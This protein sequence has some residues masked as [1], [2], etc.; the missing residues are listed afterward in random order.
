MTRNEQQAVE[1]IKS[2]TGWDAKP[3]SPNGGIVVATRPNGARLVLWR[4]QAGVWKSAVDVLHAPSWQGV[5]PTPEAAIEAVLPRYRAHV[6]G[7][8]ADLLPN[9][10]RL[11]WRE[12]INAQR[13][14]MV[15]GHTSHNILFV[16]TKLWLLVVHRSPGFA[17]VYPERTRDDV[18]ARMKNYV[19]SLNLPCCLP[20]F[21]ELSNA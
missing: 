5:G 19:E 16:D 10:P 20:P 21:P 8:A 6:A 18:L 15:V 11:E 13:L 12:S 14:V 3:K 17:N 2:V 7:M 9:W 4:S 1:A